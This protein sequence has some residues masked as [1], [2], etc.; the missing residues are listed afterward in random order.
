MAQPH[1]LQ[2]I[3]DALIPLVVTLV[4]LAFS[5]LSAKLAAKVK[6]EQARTVLLRLTEQ[7]RD[8]VVELE[9]TMAGHQR[10]AAADGKLDREE[11][12]LLKDSALANLKTYLGERGIADA[13]KVLGY[14]DQAELENVLRA[15]IEAEV[16]K[17]RGMLLGEV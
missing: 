17:V 7:A 16:A 4:G 10:A 12:Q 8:V 9:Q 11:V 1:A 15:K 5:W 14:R 2:Q 13:L 6:S 3:T